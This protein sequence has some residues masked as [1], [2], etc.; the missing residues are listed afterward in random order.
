[1]LIVDTPFPPYSPREYVYGGMPDVGDPN[2][3]WSNEPEIGL[4]DARIER[5]EG[6]NHRYVMWFTDGEQSR[7]D[8][9]PAHIIK[10]PN[11]NIEY[12]GW[13]EQN[14]NHR[15]GDL[16]ASVYF[17]PLTG[18]PTQV[19]FQKKD[20]IHR[21]SDYASITAYDGG[22][23]EIKKFFLY[24]VRVT[25]IEFFSTHAT[26]IKFNIPFWLAFCVTIFKL[27]FDATA[28]SVKDYSFLSDYPPEWTARMFG[29]SLTASGVK[30]AGAN[31][32]YGRA[33]PILSV[34]QHERNEFKSLSRSVN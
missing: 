24:G 19:H 12:L 21:L 27:D 29:L 8:G 13:L 25:D 10:P 26:A 30:L 33:F 17:S 20:Q 32:E 4:G 6:L 14:K 1:M 31:Y 2:A 34:I 18:Q 7:T 23:E 15:D 9:K 11:G 3:L 16:P 28:A 22:K 5:R